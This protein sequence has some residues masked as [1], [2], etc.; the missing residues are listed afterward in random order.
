MRKKC[1]Q[2][3]HGNWKKHSTINKNRVWHSA[4][5]TQTA[6]FLFGGGYSRTTYEY[7][8]KDS[9]QWLMGKTEISGRGFSSGCAIVVKSGQEIW[10]CNNYN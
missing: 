9:I 7:L 3:D 4:V 6:I 5:T 8:P 1:L 2:M 10:F